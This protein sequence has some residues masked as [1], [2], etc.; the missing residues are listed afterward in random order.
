MHLYALIVAGVGYGLFIDLYAGD[1]P[2][3]ALAHC[4]K[5]LAGAT[6]N[7]QQRATFS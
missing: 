3:T 6:A 2:A 1:F 7:V 5:E 4:R